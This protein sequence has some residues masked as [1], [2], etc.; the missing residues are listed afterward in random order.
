MNEVT[1]WSHQTVFGAEPA[2][3][4][5]VRDFI[6]QHLVAHDLL[7]LVEDIRSVA[8]ELAT[9]ATLR[10][11]DDERVREARDASTR[12]IV[13]LSE[14]RGVVLLAIRDGS[15]SVP[16]RNTPQVMDVDGRGLRLVETLSHEWGSSTDGSGFTSVWASFG[17][18]TRPGQ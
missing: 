14:A 6:C 8:S 12:F 3:A 13:T 17:I 11:T 5:Q 2:S 9:N 18:R 4:S 7:Y 10:A 16:F 15:T 1:G